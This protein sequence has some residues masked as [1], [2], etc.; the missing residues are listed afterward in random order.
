MKLS[1]LEKQCYNFM[2]HL[3]TE[4]YSYKGLKSAIQSDDTGMFMDDFMQGVVGGVGS[5]G[6]QHGSHNNTNNNLSHPIFG[7]TNNTTM[8]DDK[9]SQIS[10]NTFGGMGRG[11]DNKG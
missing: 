4:D 9:L 10:D 1:N 7:I 6:G 3:N 5:A 2:K 11:I 8:A